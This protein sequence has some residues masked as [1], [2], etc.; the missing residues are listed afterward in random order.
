MTGMRPRAK[1]L[2]LFVLSGQVATGCVA[3]LLFQVWL[4]LEA[5]R[6]AA[7]GASIAIV[8]GLYFALRVFAT[9]PGTPPKKILAKFY[10]GEVGKFVLTAVLFYGAV[11]WFP[12]QMLPVFLTYVVCLLVY[13]AAMLKTD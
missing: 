12:E 7:Y 8:P 11:K 13:L 4:G 2:T 3:V 1:R 5:A 6:A 10:A 9:P